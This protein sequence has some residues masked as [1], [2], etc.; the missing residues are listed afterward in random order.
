MALR[1]MAERGPTAGDGPPKLSGLVLRQRRW[2][3]LEAL[4]MRV[5][6]FF[7]LLILFLILILT[8][9]AWTGRPVDVPAYTNTGCWMLLFVS[10]FPVINKA[11]KR[12]YLLGFGQTQPTKQEFVLTTIASVVC[13]LL[14]TY[15]YVH[16]KGAFGWWVV[17]TIDWQR[18]VM[19]AA[20]WLSNFFL[21]PIVGIVVG[22][23]MVALLF[24]GCFCFCCCNLCCRGPLFRWRKTASRESRE[25]RARL[26]E[27]SK[28][29]TNEQS[30]VLGDAAS[31]KTPHP[32][33]E[34][35]SEEPQFAALKLTREPPGKDER[36]PLIDFV[37]NKGQV[38]F[39]SPLIF[40][41]AFAVGSAIVMS[42]SALVGPDNTMRTHGADP[43]H[44][45]RA[46]C[47]S[48]PYGLLH[49]V[50]SQIAPRCALDTTHAL[51]H[52]SGPT[53]PWPAHSR[54]LPC[55]IRTPCA[56]DSPSSEFTW[57]GTRSSSRPSTYAP[58]ASFLLRN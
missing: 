34:W 52:A 4:G 10:T 37:E 41:Y 30:G 26:L 22:F 40:V 43:P 2:A 25:R 28:R 51:T 23:V 17:G 16:R 49:T 46:L 33:S 47:R 27:R 7:H 18:A 20:Y 21:M 1:A 44:E 6:N 35:R 48:P 15:L 53:Y 32:K 14:A 29:P 50:A 12:T 55:P 39:L 19:L 58:T 11:A 57:R 42:G 38:S 24:T 36:E 31:G 5:E 13:L 45:I 3:K 54:P 56:V 8:S 9:F